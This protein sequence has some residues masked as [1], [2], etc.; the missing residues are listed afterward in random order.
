[1][2][3]VSAPVDD[4]LGLFGGAAPPAGGDPFADLLRA[5]ANTPAPAAKPMAPLPPGRAT[6]VDD[7]LASWGA[8][9]ARGADSYSDL[10]PAGPPPAADPFGGLLSPSTPPKYVPSGGTSA[11]IPDD[12]DPFADPFAQP[13]R[14]AAA[15]VE[16]LDDLD[17]GLGGQAATPS[18]IDAMY[19]L[20]SATPAGAPDPFAGGALGEPAP[21]TESGGLQLDPLAAL[22]GAAPG[23][24]PASQP[25]QVPELRGAYVPPAPHMDP[26]AAPAPGAFAAPAGDSGSFFQSWDDGGAGI[27]KTTIES[28]PAPRPSA[29]PASAG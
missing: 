3:P 28:R 23:F 10:I 16:P 4:P 12:F 18:S 14:G 5:P 11:A 21:R 1:V 7:P 15:G 25:D 24:P 22:S 8:S 27:S 20:G 2:T 9:A 26:L 29:R 6:P 17:F 13:P 19:G